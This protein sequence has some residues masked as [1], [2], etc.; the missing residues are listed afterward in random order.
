MPNASKSLR[1]SL[2]LDHGDA[3]REINDEPLLSEKVAAQKH[4][5]WRVKGWEHGNVKLN[6]ETGK[7]EPDFEVGD[8][9]WRHAS[10]MNLAF[11]DDLWLDQR[12]QPTTDTRPTRPGVDLPKDRDRLFVG[13]GDSH[14]N[15]DGRAPLEKLI[16]RLA[17]FDLGP[18]GFIVVAHRG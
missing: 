2:E 13:A 11:P 8:D 18:A 15:L 14:D 16:D 12:S 5:V 4:I 17:N 9:Y 1:R 7:Q 6:I 10:L 3:G